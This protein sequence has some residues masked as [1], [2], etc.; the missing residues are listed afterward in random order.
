MTMDAPEGRQRVA[1]TFGDFNG[2]GL[3]DV[4]YGKSDDKLSV[5]TGDIKRFVSTRSWKT[6]DMPSFGSAAPYDL[7]NNAAKDIILIRP[8]GYQAKRTDVIVF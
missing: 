8:G 5:Y 2:D 4:I 7:N 3:L 1:Y 6:F